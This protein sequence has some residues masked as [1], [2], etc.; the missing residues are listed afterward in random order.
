MARNSPQPPADGKCDQCGF[1]IR[2][3]ASRMRKGY[4]TH[5]C[6]TGCRNA[7][8]SANTKGEANA[9]WAGGQLTLQCEVC[10]EDFAVHPAEHARRNSRFCSRTCYHAAN[11]GENHPSWTGG[12]VETRRR[13]RQKT[14]S[15]IAYRTRT[16]LSRA[17]RRAVTNG[18]G[19]KPLQKLFGYSLSEVVARLEETMPV[20]ATWE[21]F[22]AGRLHIDHIR[23]MKAF[24]IRAAG[25]PEFMACWALSNLQLLWAEDNWRK[26]ARLDCI[27]PSGKS[28]V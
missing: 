9:T 1:P 20:G 13:S 4:K 16:R 3:L 7:W 28:N 14:K 25:D 11:R 24:D 12:V 27:A 23:P 2:L 5:F 10:G 17:I 26:N 8:L 19:G 15:S 18:K 22:H 21:D 6:G